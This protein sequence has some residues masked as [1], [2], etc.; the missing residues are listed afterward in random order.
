MEENL[1]YCTRYIEME[2]NLLYCTR[3]IEMEDNSIQIKKDLEKFI[4]EL[5]L[6][7]EVQVVEM[8]RILVDLYWGIVNN[9]I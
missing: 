8:V 9:I 5:R 6:P 1:L 3:Y 4:Y 2:E 7:A